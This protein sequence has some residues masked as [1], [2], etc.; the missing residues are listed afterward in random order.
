M[1]GI[2]RDVLNIEQ[3]VDTCGAFKQYAFPPDYNDIPLLFIAKIPPLINYNEI[4]DR[5]WKDSYNLR[6][7]VKSARKAGCQTPPV[8]S[9]A[10]LI[11]FGSWGSRALQ[12][13][14]RSNNSY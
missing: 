8:K 3:T 14:S 9:A 12:R 4:P 1:Q 7:S 11:F 10:N 5:I 2:P 13:G 6:R